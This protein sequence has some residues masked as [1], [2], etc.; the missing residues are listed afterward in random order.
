MCINVLF[1]SNI[2]KQCIQA[3]SLKLFASISYENINIQNCRIVAYEK[4]WL[5]NCDIE[6][7]PNQLIVRKA[8]NVQYKK[9]M[10]KHGNGEAKT[11]FTH[12]SCPFIN[13]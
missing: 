1:M 8:E 9:K 2:Q 4:L 5:S 7:F 6:L 11:Y 12:R 10:A 3:L 13:G